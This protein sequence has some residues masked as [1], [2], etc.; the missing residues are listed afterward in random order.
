MLGACSPRKY[1]YG[2][3]DS[4]RAFLRHSGSNFYLSA[5]SQTL[6]I[7]TE[8]CHNDVVVWARDNIRGLMQP[9]P[10]FPKWGG[11]FELPAPT[12]YFSALV[13]VSNHGNEVPAT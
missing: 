4:L 9:P 1:Y 11:G 13:L 5:L 12:P 7:M 10:L 8:L 6:R 3:F 2:N